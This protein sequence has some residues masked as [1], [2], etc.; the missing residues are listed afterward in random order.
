MTASKYQD[1]VVLGLSMPKLTAL[2]HTHNHALELDRTLDSLR[3]CDEVL[4]I[5][6]DS[7]DGTEKVARDH[8]ASVKKAIAG[9]TPGAYA[10]DA[11]HEWVLCLRPNESLSD[12]LGAAL[13]EWKDR[14]IDPEIACFGVAICQEN[15]DGWEQLPPEVRLVNRTLLN[16]VGEMPPQQVCSEILKGDLLSFQQPQPEES[17]VSR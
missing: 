10:M 17:A 14:E 13:L 1:A 12:D 15:G 11:V 9:V 6:D 16:W 2:I 5:D 8:G 3:V 4:I 7:E